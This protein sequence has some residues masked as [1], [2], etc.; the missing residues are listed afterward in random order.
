MSVASVILQGEDIYIY[1][2]RMQCF[3]NIF[4]HNVF[5]DLGFMEHTFGNLCYRQQGVSE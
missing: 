2:Y 3:L 5:Q 1:I 4:E